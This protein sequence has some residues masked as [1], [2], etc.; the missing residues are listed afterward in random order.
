MKLSL[1]LLALLAAC[2]PVTQTT[3]KPAS[4]EVRVLLNIGRSQPDQR[5]LQAL[6]Q[7][8]KEIGYTVLTDET[9]SR[10]FGLE[11]DD[12]VAGDRNQA[13]RLMETSK[14]T[15]GVFVLSQFSA[16]DPPPLS[17]FARYTEIKATASIVD[18]SGRLVRRVEAIT[19]GGIFNPNS[20]IT[21]A[22]A[23]TLPAAMKAVA[24]KVNEVINP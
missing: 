6:N 2:V 11:Y 20:T 17:G 12:G 16:K 22:V 13:V 8:F 19:S 5:T 21:D 14:A 10:N 3:V 9:L 7:S 15:Y 4:A 23:A 18:A 24:V 1:L